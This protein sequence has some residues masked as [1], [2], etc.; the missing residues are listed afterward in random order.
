VALNFF[1][2]TLFEPKITLPRLYMRVPVRSDWSEWAEIR[3]DSRGFLVPW[4][5]TW[6]ADSL[7][8]AAFRRRLAKYS[9]DWSNDKGYA[10]LIFRRLDNALVGG[11]TIANVRRGV[12]QS[13]SFGY[14]ISRKHARNGYMTEGVHGACGFAF[15]NL[16]LNRIEAACLPINK[17]SQ[18]VLTKSGFR[19]EGL[20]KKYLKINGKWED[21]MMFAL[22]KEEF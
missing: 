15:D 12:A 2:S 20:A 7:S 5:P 18:G 13:A 14:W 6:P 4:E 16:S 8:K 1:P 17:P 19:Y 11:I 9:E 21:H 3:S 22:L 10:F